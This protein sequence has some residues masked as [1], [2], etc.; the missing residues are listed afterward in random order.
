LRVKD[1]AAVGDGHPVARA[2]VD[3]ALE[4]SAVVHPSQQRV[5]ADAVLLAIKGLAEVVADQKE[6]R[7]GLSKGEQ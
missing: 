3:D 1:I 7:D 5:F 6:I 4:V 2:H